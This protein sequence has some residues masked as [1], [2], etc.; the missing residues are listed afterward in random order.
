PVYP[1][2]VRVLRVSAADEI[3]R[4]ER[5]MV[6]VDAYSGE[7]DRSDEAGLAAR[8]GLD[9]GR[10]RQAQRARD[11]L[12]LLCL[13]RIKL[14]IPAQHQRHGRSRAAG[15]EQGLE[16]ALGAHLQRSTDF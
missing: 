1:A 5:G 11:P 6:G 12:E 7:A 16:A 9:L 13:D 3:R 8:G 10:A 14:V 4:G 15:Y 2:E